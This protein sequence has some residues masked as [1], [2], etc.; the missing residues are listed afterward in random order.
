M[1]FLLCLKKMELG[2]LACATNFGIL[3]FNRGFVGAEALAA[4]NPNMFS[5]FGQ[6]IVLV[7]GVAFAA[8]GVSDAGPAVWAAFALEKLCYVVG[9]GLWFQLYRTPAI[10]AVASAWSAND[11]S[12]LLPA[13]FHVIY[14]PVDFTFMC[15]FLH[16]AFSSK[17]S[18]TQRSKKE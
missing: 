9:W 16:Q 12:K 2:A 11:Y 1:S 6:G 17:R 3:L 13:S 7:W 14:G 8:A 15:L 18:P 5:P 4:P 10:A